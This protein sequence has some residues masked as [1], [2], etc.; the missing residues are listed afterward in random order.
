MISGYKTISWCAGIAL[1]VFMSPELQSLISQHPVEAFWLNNIVVVIL[2]H[3]TVAPLPW[4][5][6][7]E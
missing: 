7:R 1:A 6:F 2:R 3:F 4:M 5:Q